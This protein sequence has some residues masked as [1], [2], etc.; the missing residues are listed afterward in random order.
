MKQIKRLLPCVLFIIAL[1]LVVSCKKQDVP[2]VLLDVNAKLWINDS[3]ASFEFPESELNLPKTGICL[4]GG[5][6][7]AM[8]AGTGQLKALH[9]IGAL[10]NAGYLSCVSGGSWVSVPFTYYQSGAKNDEEL[11]GTIIPADKLT[12]DGMDLVSPSFL[13]GAANRSLLDTIISHV[14]TTSYDNLWIEGVKRCYM[15]PF[16]LLEDKFYSWND[17]TVADI[18]KRNPS[19]TP[20]QFITVHNNQGDAHRPYLVVNSCIVGPYDLGPFS[21]PEPLSVFNYTPL[22]NGSLVLNTPKYISEISKDVNYRTIGGGFIESFAYGATTPP[23]LPSLCDPNT[24]NPYCVQLAEEENIFTIG[25]ASGT[26]SS[27]FVS[28]LTSKELLHKSLKVLSPQVDYWPILKDSIINEENYMFR[29]GGNLENFGLISLLQRSVNKVVI[30]VNTETPIN[31]KYDI[32]S[33]PKPNDI[34]SDVYPLFGYSNGPESDMNLNQVFPKDSFK[35]FVQQLIDAKNSGNTVMSKITMP[36][37]AN[38]WWGIPAGKEIETL[39]IY[40]DKVKNWEKDLEWEIK[41]EID[42]GIVG[43]FRDFPNYR[44]AM[45]NLGLVQLTNRQINLLYQLSAWN[46]Y[47]NKEV[48]DFL[49]N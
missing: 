7:R 31:T 16:G 30:F 26:S 6:T 17:S 49:G 8:V 12:L 47:S 22:Y 11:L 3:N 4:S 9:E 23:N 2:L 18:C 5:G 35:V 28:T 27:A 42:L 34:D 36:T 44:T 10:D 38:P 24:D 32:N 19:L 39:W 40:N 45:E 25:D 37:I 1:C 41:A 46:V 21:N 15:A 20:D 13:A 43:E 33:P 14:S 29:D 48:F